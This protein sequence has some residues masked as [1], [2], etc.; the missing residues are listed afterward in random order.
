MKMTRRKLWLS[1]W[2]LLPV[3]FVSGLLI[4][5]LFSKRPDNLGLTEGRLRACPS[6]PNCVCSYSESADTEHHIEPL[7]IPERFEQPMEALVKV[8]ESLPRTTIVTREENYLHT[9]FTSRLLRFVDDVE[10]QILPDENQIHVR[11]A[12]RV[13]YSDLGANRKR[14]EQIRAEWRKVVQK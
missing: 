14:V 3:L 5:S 11:S 1:V 9:E 10:F 8:L 12:S 2:I 13:G 6:S 7:E 4:M